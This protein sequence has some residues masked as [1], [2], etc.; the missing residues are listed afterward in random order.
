MSLIYIFYLIVSI[1]NI[2]FSWIY[3]NQM[4]K[5]ISK[6]KPKYKKWRVYLTLIFMAITP[7]SNI[8]TLLMYLTSIDKLKQL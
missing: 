8:L 5:I 2:V 3:F 6:I 1:S 7:I 4:I